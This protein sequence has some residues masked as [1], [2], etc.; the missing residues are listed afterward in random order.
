[1]IRF[2]ETQALSFGEC[3]GIYNSF[4]RLKTIKLSRL[5]YI[6]SFRKASASRNPQTA[7]TGSAASWRF[8]EE[9]E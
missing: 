4:I 8:S 9:K 1:M 2:L 3:K 6:Q 5:L 7:P